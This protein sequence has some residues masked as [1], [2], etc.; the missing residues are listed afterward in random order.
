MT[1]T[2]A[3]YLFCTPS[4]DNYITFLRAKDRREM[5]NAQ[6]GEQSNAE[7]MLTDVAG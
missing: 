4:K 3:W 1:M 2:I 6:D 5:R 7:I